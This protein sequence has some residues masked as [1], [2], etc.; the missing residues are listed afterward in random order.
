M[1]NYPNLL[2]LWHEDHSKI[3]FVHRFH[4]VVLSILG[5]EFATRE[6]RE[7]LLLASAHMT[8]QETAQL[9]SKSCLFT[10]SRKAIEAIIE[11]T[12]ELLESQHTLPARF[13]KETSPLKE[14]KVFATSMYGINVLL[15][16]PAPKQGLQRQRPSEKYSPS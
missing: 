4:E 1:P 5:G 6:L 2:L 15:R 7:N 12:G 14:V 10:P 8:V 9:I 3:L 11:E 13:Y 16:E